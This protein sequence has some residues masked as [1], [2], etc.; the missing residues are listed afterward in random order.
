MLSLV[1]FT[2]KNCRLVAAGFAVLA[3]LLSH[4]YAY[5]S[6]KEAARVAILQA[7]VEAYKKRAEINE[8][9]ESLSDYELCKRLP[10]RLRNDCDILRG[11]NTAP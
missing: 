2:V 8:N 11:A 3:L 6:G 7:E 5:N 4:V 9:V 10:S 1:G